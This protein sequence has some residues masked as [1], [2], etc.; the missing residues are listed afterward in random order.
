M[1]ERAWATAG[2]KSSLD[3]KSAGRARLTGAALIV[4]SVMGAVLSYLAFTVW[5]PGQQER[6][7]HYRA[8]EPCPA[9]AT[10]QEVAA[11]DCLTTWHFTVT[12]AKSTFTG[13]VTA[14]EATLKDKGDDSWQ[15]VVRFSDSGPLF[16]KLHRG[17]EVT[18]TG[19]RRDIVVLSKDGVRQNTSDAPRDEHQGN[20]ALGV[21]L[22]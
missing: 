4:L 5:G 15:R 3:R 6:Y 19:W 12:K 14:Y 7:E 18:A 2:K 11:K 21:L 22:A 1:A 17:D 13:K 8:A 9:Q 10:P 16:D 20:A